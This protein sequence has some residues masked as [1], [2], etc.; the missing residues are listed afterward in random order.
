MADQKIS[1]FNV[2]TSLNDSDLFTFVVNGTN[3]NITYSDL[4]LDLGVTGSLSQTGDPLGV[5]VLEVESLNVYNIRNI[6]SSK[7]VI[8]SVSAENGIA[9]GANFI[10]STGGVPVIEDLNDDIYNFRTIKAEAPLQVTVEGDSIVIKETGSPLAVTNTV[11]VSSIDDF[12]AAASGVITLD[13]GI[14]YV[15]AQPITTSNRFVL[16][17]SNS[18]TANNPFSPLFSYTGTGT[19]FTGVDVTLTIHDILLSAPSGQVFDMSSTPS[20]GGNLFIATLVIVLDCNK[21]GTFDDLLTFDFTNGGAI[22]AN[23]GITVLGSTNWSIFSITKFSSNTL[24]ASFVGID[25]GSSV[26]RTLELD[27]LV[28]RGVAGGVGISGLT[29]NGNVTSGN[30]ASVTGGEFTGL[31]PLNGI[32]S[33]DSRWAFEGNTNI[34]DSMSDALM[35]FNGNVLETVIATINTPVVINA[36]W[37]LEDARRFTTTTGGRATYNSEQLKHFPV[38]ISIGLISVGGGAINVTTYLCLNGATVANTGRTVEISGSSARTLS[39][40]WQLS[41]SENDYLEVCIEN[42][43]GTG[44]VIVENAILRVN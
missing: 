10:Q 44:N 27:N 38:D 20:S 1:Q 8:A 34:T 24:S 12:P 7:G 36:A 2:S 37:T 4:K 21:F 18:I 39:I 5:P 11:I 40:P 28:F 14:N 26:H 22:S 19:F 29:S 31:T 3:K 32:S 9:I 33:D 43:S 42:N 17:A 41:L 16:G 13:D 25:F 23:D 30:L 15:I 35:G 6:E